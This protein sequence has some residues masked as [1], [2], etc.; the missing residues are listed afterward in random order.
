MFL[1]KKDGFFYDYIYMKPA[2][3]GVLGWDAGF[4]DCD[5]VGLGVCPPEPGGLLAGPVGDGLFF[6]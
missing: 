1:S 4:E 2:L 3:C 5:P 6:K